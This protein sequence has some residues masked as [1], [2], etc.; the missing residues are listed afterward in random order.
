MSTPHTTAPA[1]G[2]QHTPGPFTA[3]HSAFSTSA[4]AEVH[5]GTP[6]FTVCVVYSDPQSTRRAEVDANVTLLCAAPDLLAALTSLLEL[7]ESMRD[8]IALER[9]LSGLLSVNSPRIALAKA[10][11]A[12][13]KGAT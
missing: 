8:T 9:G 1:L 2:A 7:T 5:I 12:K 4:L 10:A 13:A 11:I 6:E 3:T